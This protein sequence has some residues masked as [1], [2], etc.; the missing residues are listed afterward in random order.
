[1]NIE[2]NQYGVRGLLA[3]KKLSAGEVI[4]E[5]PFQYCFQDDYDDES[6]SWSA[7]MG[8]KLLEERA[9]GVKSRR[10]QKWIESLPV[11]APFLPGIA[12]EREEMEELIR[13][14]PCVK[15]ALKD[16]DRHEQSTRLLKDRL[17]AIS[18]T[19]E[20]LDWAFALMESRCFKDGGVRITA[21]GIDCATTQ[22]RKR[23]VSF[24]SSQKC[25]KMKRY[26]Q[27]P[28]GK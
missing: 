10:Y 26:T 24:G 9:K 7:R 25:L 6:L 16:K 19:S 23:I 17:D 27:K 3:Q 12:L 18:C 4:F 22:A 5:I 21:P 2:T 20:D 14:P 11:E 8:M 13:Y 15:N 1:V 28:K